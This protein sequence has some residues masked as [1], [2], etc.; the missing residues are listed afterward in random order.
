MRPFLILLTLLLSFNV[1]AART[2]TDERIHACTSD[3]DS[4]YLGKNQEFRVHVVAGDY[5]KV[6]RLADKKSIRAK[7]NDLA[8]VYGAGDLGSRRGGYLF[9]VNE[10]GE[11]T[12]AI[13]V[14]PGSYEN[15]RLSCT[16]VR[17]VQ[18][19][20]PMTATEKT[21]TEIAENAA[22][23]N[24]SADVNKFD[25]KKFDRSKEQ[26]KLAT[27]KKNWPGCKWR[28]YVT[29]EKIFNMIEKDA[30]DP[31]SAAKLK[32][33]EKSPGLFN[34]IALASDDSISCSQ[35]YV[36]VYTSDGYKLSLMYSQ[37]D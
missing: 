4:K 32:A 7:Q 9:D 25:L 5:I 24:G 19:L 30:Y 27:W 6:T 13:G 34:M 12:I 22:L 8:Y 31:E 37:G 15:E 1:Q 20:D 33:I 28:T 14:G 3:A 21:L 17:Q 18:E 16:L 11:M 23:A 29:R 2:E 35:R 36:W 26:A 10:R